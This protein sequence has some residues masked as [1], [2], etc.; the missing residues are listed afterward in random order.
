MMHIGQLETFFE[1]LS[2]QVLCTFFKK[3]SLAVHPGLSSYVSIA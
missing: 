1:E 3:Q 2:A